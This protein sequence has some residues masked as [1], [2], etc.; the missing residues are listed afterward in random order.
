MQFMVLERTNIIYPFDE[1]CFEE[2]GYR[3]LNPEEMKVLNVN[4]DDEEYHAPKRIPVPTRIDEISRDY[5]VYIQNEYGDKLGPRIP[6][7][8]PLQAAREEMMMRI[9]GYNQ[10]EAMQVGHELPLPEGFN[11]M[12]KSTL[13]QFAEGEGITVEMTGSAAAVRARIINALELKQTEQEAA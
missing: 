3:G 13:Q 5:I 12:K 2:G 1:E 9:I 4:P 11:R 7:S 8:M 10:K 6:N